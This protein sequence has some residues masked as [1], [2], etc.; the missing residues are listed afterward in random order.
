[1][2]SVENMKGKGLHLGVRRAEVFNIYLTLISVIASELF[3]MY[4]T[5]GDG[6]MFKKCQSLSWARKSVN[7]GGKLN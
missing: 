2:I 6:R 7:D 1:M 3:F 5:R 4:G